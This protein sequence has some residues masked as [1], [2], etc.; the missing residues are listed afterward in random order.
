MLAL[1]R[2]SY[3]DKITNEL[4]GRSD[5]RSDNGA[6]GSSE[7]RADTVA[8]ELNGCSDDRSD[9]G[10]IGPIDSSDDR[11]V[12]GANDLNGREPATK[13][14]PLGILVSTVWRGRTICDFG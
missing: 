9:S 14:V 10:T 13:E 8:T 1:V 4:N 6:Y 11:A 5:D 3:S 2:S 7:V 12:S